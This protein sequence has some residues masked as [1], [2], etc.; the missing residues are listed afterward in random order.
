MGVVQIWKQACL[1]LT[2]YAPARW[3]LADILCNT[4]R[5]LLSWSHFNELSH[6][7]KPRVP[8][9]TYRGWHALAFKEHGAWQEVYHA[10]Y[11]SRGLHCSDVSSWERCNTWGRQVQNIWRDG[12]KGKPDV[13]KFDG[14]SS[15]KMI[16]KLFIK[17]I[18]YLFI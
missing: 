9:L 12:T 14:N 10:V 1:L 5:N 6:H 2:Q 8:I 13:Y 15:H 17:F 3:Q 16:I 18:Y 7:Y 4:K 11:Q